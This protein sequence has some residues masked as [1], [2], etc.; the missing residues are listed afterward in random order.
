MS[1]RDFNAGYLAAQQDYLEKVD[2]IKELESE[3][4]SV[5]D[6]PQA[7]LDNLRCS[8]ENYEFWAYANLLL[9]KPNRKWKQWREEDSNGDYYDYLKSRGIDAESI[10]DESMRNMKVFK[11]MVDSLR[12]TKKESEN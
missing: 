5:E 3:G 1:K 10:K 7:L 8:K 12:N 6:V 9:N 4:V 2:L 11:E